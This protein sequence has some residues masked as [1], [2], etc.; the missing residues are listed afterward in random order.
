MSSLT[1]AALLG[2]SGPAVAALNISATAAIDT[3]RLGEFVPIEFIV[4]NTD[5]FSRTGVQITMVYPANLVQAFEIYFDGDCPSTTCTEGETVTWTLGTVAADSAVSVTLPVFVSPGAADG[6]TITFAPTVTDDTPDN[7][8]ASTSVIVDTNAAYDV[9]LAE[10]RDP[11]IAGSQLTYR[12]SYGYRADAAAVSLSTLRFP[13]PANTTFVSATG[14]GTL[15]A[16]N[17][18]WVLGNLEP[19]DSGV[20]E[21]TVQLD[22]SLNPADLVSAS[23]ELFANAT[24]TENVISQANT[25]IGQAGG[26]ALAVESNVNPSRP[27]E[28]AHINLLVTNTDPFTQLGVTLEVYT[29]EDL[30]QI[31]ETAFDGDCA[32]TTCTAGETISFTLGDIPANGSVTVHIPPFVQN[33]ATGG[34]L[35]S[36]LAT[37]TDSLGRQAR[38]T[39]TL[40][41]QT[42][43]R[44]DLSIAENSD[45]ATAGA[46]LTYRLNFGYR[47]DAGSVSNTLLRLPIPDNLTFSSATEGG[48]IVS[49]AV[50]WALGVLLPGDSGIREATF[51]LDGGLSAADV[52]AATAEISSVTDPGEAARAEASTVIAA[53]GGLQLAIENNPGPGRITELLN[54]DLTVSNTDVFPRFGVE[55]IGIFPQDL[56][57][58]FETAF[59][60]DCGSTTCTGGERVTFTLGQINAGQTVTLNMPPFIQNIATGGELINFF[61]TAQDDQGAQTRQLE[62]VR[63]QSDSQYELT[64]HESS[65][66]ALAGTNLDY[67]LTYA[68]R[69]DA[70][71]V[72]QSVLRMPL[73]DGTAFVSATGGGVLN[74]GAVEWQLGFLQPGDNGIREVTLAL[75]GGLAAAA[76]VE[77]NAEIFSTSLPIE[78]ARAEANTSIAS[79]QPLSLAI[80]TNPDAARL[81]ELGELVFTVTNNDPF[82]RFGVELVGMFPQNYSQSFELYFDGD[83]GSTSCS[84]G[85]TVTWQLGDIP[86]GDSKTVGMQVDVVPNQ[87]GDALIPLFARATDDQGTQALR[88]DTMRIQPDTVYDVALNESA[89]PATPGSTLVYDVTWGYRDDAAAVADT[90]LHLNLPDGVTFQSASDGGV[91]N[92]DA[93]EWGLG[94]LQ[95]GN[96]G[97]RTATV[98]IDAGTSAGTVLEASADLH[99]GST[100]D[101]GARAETNTVVRASAPLSLEITPVVFS[102]IDGRPIQSFIKVTNNDAFTRFGVTLQGRFPEHLTQYFESDPDFDGDCSSTSCTA[103]ERI[104]WPVVDIPAGQSVTVSFA[105]SP[106]PTVDG[107]LINFLAWVE[108]DQGV[109]ARAGESYPTGCIEELDVDCD[110][111]AAGTDN[112]LVVPN[113]P[114]RD[115][116]GDGFGNRCDADLNND[117]IVDLND[118]AIFR[119]AFLTTPADAAWN[120]DADLDGNDSVGLQDLAI[121]RQLFLLPP[122]PN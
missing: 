1:L 105:P 102:A 89:D 32:S 113:T 55:L 64:L 43:T 115:T 63:V 8:S 17:V 22:G 57:Q 70:A 68:Y 9:G 41:V 122:G 34:E 10:S 39:E 66:P 5:G 29:P 46:S 88:G 106:S 84:T 119:A 56:T 31:F 100:P 53:Q 7:D 35:I 25:V 14:G 108:D 4:T 45:P 52:I 60:G 40:R 50:Q 33:I 110:G 38:H 121:V 82:M 90:S 76:M 103:S 23:A 107:R 42:D 92:G 81:D 2:V 120:P 47:E 98:T 97:I 20:R 111:V 61:M 73:P 87:T 99:G 78:R 18:D 67:K 24:P 54:L 91:L 95:P 93:V 49:G 69:I 86:A 21:V 36:F 74:A 77:A 114:Q 116:D 80:E 94:F 65:D 85:E 12:I 79:T 28:L 75:N 118:L 11:A 109:Q 6:A 44:Y 71:A 101:D 96:A 48:S 16:G 62:T 112:C 3:G 26:L 117:N 37:V 58:L 83:C 30:E 13:V 72:S 15:N 27:S 104:T 19:G 51:T 59:D